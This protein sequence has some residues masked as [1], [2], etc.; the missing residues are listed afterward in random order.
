MCSPTSGLNAGGLTLE[1]VDRLAETLEAPR[2][3]RVERQLRQVFNPEKEEGAAATRRIAELV[4]ELGLQPFRAP[5]PLPPIEP[6]EV[7]LVI[8]MALQQPLRK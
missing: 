5:K 8:W 7:N 3:I 6:D 1:E 2:S 4:K